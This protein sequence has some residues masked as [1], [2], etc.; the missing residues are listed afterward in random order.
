MP[1]PNPPS[2]PTCITS[3]N[4]AH[5]TNLAVAQHQAAHML[6]LLTELRKNGVLDELNPRLPSR[7]PA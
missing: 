4:A 7:G 1:P 6:E 2:H 3:G 5:I